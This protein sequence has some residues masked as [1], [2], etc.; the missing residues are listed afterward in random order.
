MT[1]QNTQALGPFNRYAIWVQGCLR[2]CPGCVSKDSQPLESGYV[3]DIEELA[4]NILCTPG[5]EGITISGGE[6]F[7]QAEALVGLIHI[8][9][10]Q[11]DLGVILY[12]GYRMDEIKDNELTTLCDLVIDGE[13]REDLNDGLSLRGSSN[14]NV[15]MITQRYASEIC[16]YYEISG[17]KI[18]L[19]FFNGRT[20]MV[21]IPEKSSLNF[22]ESEF[23]L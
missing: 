2:G 9:K 20:T 11:K 16:K 12:T 4:K 3:L 10:K 7:L 21:G 22:F 6:P 15:I 1:I 14:Q 18:E 8:L 23:V 19:H 17:R 5:I 13:Y